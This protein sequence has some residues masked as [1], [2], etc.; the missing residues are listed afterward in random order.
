MRKVSCA[1]KDCEYS[2]PVANI[3]GRHAHHRTRKPAPAGATRLR[4][5]PPVG[6]RCS[7]A[8]GSRETAF[9]RAPASRRSCAHAV[10]PL[11]HAAMRAV[12]EPLRH[13][14]CVDI[15]QAVR[16]GIERGLLEARCEKM[17]LAGLCGLLLRRR[18]DKTMQTSDWGAESGTLQRVLTV[19]MHSDSQLCQGSGVRKS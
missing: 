1:V 2:C 15:Q 9:G 14:Y 12:C 6:T 11:R 13:A 8:A 5:E 7:K 3:S 19:V 10:C 16:A 17:G 4:R 18:L